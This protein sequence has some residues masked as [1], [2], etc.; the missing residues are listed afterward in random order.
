LL[1][2]SLLAAI[3]VPGLGIGLSNLLIAAA[4]LALLWL[5]RADLRQHHRRLLPPLLAGLAV[6]LWSFVAALAGPMPEIGL[7]SAVK[8]AFYALALGGALALFAAPARVTGALRMV[9]GFLL[10]LAGFGVVEA[11][12]P[13][14]WPFL[15]LRS[16]D[17]L[18]ITPR[19]ASLLPW[20]NQFG[21]VMV[22]GLVVLELLAARRA[23]RP[24]LAWGSRL[25][26]LVQ[27][28]QSGSRNSWLLLGAALLLLVVL[29]S[30]PWRRAVVL[31]AVFA[32]I[33]V[34]L[35]VPARQL[36]LRQGSWLPAANQMIE[37]PGG[38]SPSLAPAGLSLSLRSQLWREAVAEI[39]QHPVAGLGSNVFQAYAG[40]RVMHEFGFNTH[41]LLLEVWV[42]LGTVGLLL[43]AIAAVVAVRS[44]LRGDGLG[45]LPLAVLLLAQVLDCFTHDPTVV[46]LMALLAGAAWSRPQAP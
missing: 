30:T 35:P 13:E 15:L 14:S 28:G 4:G 26:L 17:S 42:G 10:L 36:G 34:T 31:G 41:N 38:W 19:V 23:I 20:P 21:A 3:R 40:P 22:L 43:V 45:G 8:G 44:R 46:V 16:E 27:V 25:L 11:I 1:G 32:V 37:T 6:W 18:S 2:G 5:Y 7:R 9:L 33:V 12:F 29:R 39:R 24:G